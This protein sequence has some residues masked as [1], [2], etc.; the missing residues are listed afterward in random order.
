MPE[1]K[2]AEKVSD[3][4]SAFICSVIGALILSNVKLCGEMNGGIGRD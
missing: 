3:N 4:R 1:S 2:R